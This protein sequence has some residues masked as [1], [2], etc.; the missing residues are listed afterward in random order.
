MTNENQPSSQA[1]DS[2][3]YFTR[4]LLGLPIIPGRHYL[5]VGKDEIIDAGEFDMGRRVWVTHIHVDD[6]DTV[7]V[8]DWPARPYTLTKQEINDQKFKGGFFISRHYRWA[9]RN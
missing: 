5:K 3:I 7:T 4:R 2:H 1:P 8:K 9:D 6:P